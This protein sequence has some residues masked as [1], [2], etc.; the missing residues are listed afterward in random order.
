MAQVILNNPSQFV[1]GIPQNNGVYYDGSTHWLFYDD[2]SGTL[3]CK[4]GSDL[5]AMSDTFTN[6]AGTDNLTN[7]LNN[8][9][10]WAVAFGENGGNHYAWGIVSLSDLTDSWW[11]TRWTL[12]S[13]GLINP[14]FDNLNLS[15]AQRLHNSITPNYSGD[16]T[17]LLGASQINNSSASTRQI[18]FGLTTDDGLGAVDSSA[19]LFP[20]H[21][22]VFKL[23]DGY[24]AFATDEGTTGEQNGNFGHAREW[25][26]PDL[27]TAW[28]VENTIEGNVTGASSNDGDFADQNY[29][30]GTS[31]AGQQDICQLIDG[32]IYVAYCDNSDLTNG[33]YGEIKLIKRGNAQASGWTLVSNDVIGSNQQAWHIALS[34]NGIDIWIVYVKNNGGARDDAIYYRKYTV[35]TDTLGTETKIA[36]IQPGQTF[37]RMF[38]QWRFTGDS[39][40]VAWSEFDGV[41]SYDALIENVSIAD[42]N[43][44]CIPV[45]DDLCNYTLAQLKDLGFT[46]SFPSSVTTSG[47][48]ASSNGV[49]SGYQL[50]DLSVNMAFG[51]DQPFSKNISNRLTILDNDIGSNV[52]GDNYSVHT[53]IE[54][55]Q[56]TNGANTGLQNTNTI[57]YSIGAKAVINKSL[58]DELGN[59]ITDVTGFYPNR[60]LGYL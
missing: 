53:T 55:I 15:D 11:W 60:F 42:S 51:A 14:V 39:F 20:E 43:T 5:S 6:E 30:I 22:R 29:A 7:I 28:S 38:T 36:D 34:S 17:E 41:S 54:D 27:P 44:G 40:D 59:N 2:S 50:I 45:I 3:K 16:V 26:R 23:T 12:S 24:L 57:S 32:T 8:G 19:I 58:D 56:A 1:V 21:T 31:H 47:F 35:A 25:T 13:S 4:Y 49:G 46:I 9:K 33:T 48:I 52:N 37:H 10:T 18:D